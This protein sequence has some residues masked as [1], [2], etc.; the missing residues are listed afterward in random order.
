[1]E[2]AIRRKKQFIYLTVSF[3]I[4]IAASLVFGAFFSISTREQYS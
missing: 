2:R 1:M 4:I 3:I